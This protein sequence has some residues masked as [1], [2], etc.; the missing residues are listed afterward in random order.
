[1]KWLAVFVKGMKEQIRDY[2]I[3]LMVVVM[4]PLFISIYFLMA[5]TD[6]PSYEVIIVNLDRD[7]EMKVKQNNP[8]ISLVRLVAA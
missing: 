6:S 4:A 2:W 1:M 7:L 8:G 5:E 3:L